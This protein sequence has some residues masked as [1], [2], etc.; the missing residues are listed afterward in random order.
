MTT[1][2]AHVHLQPQAVPYARHLPTPVPHY[3]KSTIKESLDC[4]MD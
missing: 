4:D 1:P 3:W 2:P